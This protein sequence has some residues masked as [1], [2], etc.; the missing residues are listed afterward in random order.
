MKFLSFLILFLAFFDLA[1]AQNLVDNPGFEQRESLDCIDC[2]I[3][4]EEFSKKM[5][6]WTNLNT[7]TNICDC[8]YEKKS[9]EG[10]YKYGSICP[11]EKVSPKE[12]CV[13][14]QMGYKPQCLDWDHATEGC[15]SYLSTNL[16]EKL[17][18]GKQYEI[19]YWLYILQPDDPGYEQHIGFTLFPQKIRNPKG[20][21]IPQNVFKIDTVI[22][23]QWYPVKWKIQPTCPLQ[24]LVVGVFRGVDGP[25]VH[26]INKR[27]DNFYFVD[28]ISVKEIKVD[29]N[30][31][32]QNV[33]FFCKPELIPGVSVRPEIEGCTAYFESGKDELSPEYQLALDAFALRVKQ[34]PETAFIVSG[35]T[36][37]VGSDHIS[38]S[39]RRIDQVLSYLEIKHKI[40]KI[41][42]LALPKGDSDPT[43]SNTTEQG[44][45]NNRRVEIQ[46][47]DHDIENVIYRNML[48]FIFQKDLTAAYKTLNIWL[49]FAPQKSKL[50]MLYDPR[51]DALKTG[52]RWQQITNQVRDSYKIFPAGI[53]LSFSLDSLWAED[54]KSRTL[55]FYIENLSTYIPAVDSTQSRWDVNFF[56]SESEAKKLDQENSAALKNLIGINYWIKQSEVGERAA[57][58]NFLIFQHIMNVNVL[59]TYL[60][61][62]KARCMEGEAPWQYYAMMYDRLQIIQGLPQRYGT[63]FRV[64]DDG[65]ELFPLEDA[66]QVD[67]WRDEIGMP[68]L[69]DG[70]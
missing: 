38:L 69:G 10:K 23:N 19:S 44:K 21:M 60:P 20:A 54:Q 28:N 25:P 16:T 67:I 12:G 42:F 61:L 27:T 55:K 68:A 53:D 31:L 37:N 6:S 66:E 62:L 35:H 3:F 29:K 64:T 11:L 65:Q 22:Y 47:R 7:H 33:T 51:I 15:T 9:T 24:N 32:Q 49:H 57:T 58:A 4:N 70:Q 59:K 18:M 40:P 56:L 30:E 39:E 2:H 43:A 63:Q 1:F 34:Y 14:I 45:Q 17:Q 26:H 46:H 13:M 36:D 52:S 48:N 5:S 41:R 8:N 50:L